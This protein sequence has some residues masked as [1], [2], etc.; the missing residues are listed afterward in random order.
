MANIAFFG[1]K[2]D[3]TFKHG[4]SR[5]GRLCSC[6]RVSIGGHQGDPFHPTYMID[7]ARRGSGS[8]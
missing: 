7:I 3:R 6:W 1:R 8:L 4:N 2:I 5:R